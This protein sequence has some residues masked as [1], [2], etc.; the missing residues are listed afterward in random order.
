MKKMFTS[1]HLIQT[2]LH[3]IQ[4]SVSYA[5]MLIFMTYNAYLAIAV[6]AGATI[7]Y[8]LFGWKKALVVDVNEHC[9]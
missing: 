3:G 1:H 2:L 7:G 4:V 9:H 6:V 5:L 8:F